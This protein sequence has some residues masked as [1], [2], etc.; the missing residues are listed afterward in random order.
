MESER[1][2]DMSH[3]LIPM[4]RKVVGVEVGAG[5]AAEDCAAVEDG[6]T[7]EDGAAVEGDITCEADDAA[8]EDSAEEYDDFGFEDMTDDGN[9]LPKAL[10]SMLR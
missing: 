7:A 5:A 8:E 4:E 3:G 10:S 9:S 2:A 6:A 1:S